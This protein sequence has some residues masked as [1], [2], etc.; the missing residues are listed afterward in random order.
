MA[1]V[2]KNKLLSMAQQ[3]TTKEAAAM[4]QNKLEA[5]RAAYNRVC[6]YTAQDGTEVTLMVKPRLSLSEQIAM[7][8]SIVNVV[9]DAQT[10]AY[11]PYMRTVAAHRTLLKL[12]VLPMPELDAVLTDI[13][14][15]YE[16]IDRTNIMEEV[17]AVV[18][19]NIPALLG[20]ADECI[21]HERKRTSVDRFLS[22]LPDLLNNTNGELTKIIAMAAEQLGASGVN[23]DGLAKPAQ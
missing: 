15:T 17:M 3:A 6:V 10:G 4:F 1:K 5:Q 22:A 19:T 13:D 21:E 18:E 8:R 14:A 2:S 12:V 20:Y 16:L 11:H 7:V 23:P 9:V